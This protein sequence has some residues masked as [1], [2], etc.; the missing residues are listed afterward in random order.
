[1]L[2]VQ[3]SMQTSQ[4]IQELRDELAKTRKELNEAIALLH[5]IDTQK[6]ETLVF[7]LHQ[8]NAAAD[9]RLFALHQINAMQDI[10][11]TVEALIKERDEL[12]DELGQLRDGSASEP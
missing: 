5:E 7:A 8:L 12:K 3:M 11:G 4:Q 2:W 9:M 10:Y 6:N 1:M